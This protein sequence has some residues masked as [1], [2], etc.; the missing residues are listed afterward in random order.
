MKDRRFERVQIEFIKEIIDDTGTRSQLGRLIGQSRVIEIRNELKLY[1]I[2]KIYEGV[3]DDLN[4]PNIKTSD[5]EETKR[6]LSDRMK[7]HRDDPMTYEYILE[8]VLF[9]CLREVGCRRVKDSYGQNIAPK[10]E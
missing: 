9:N 6:Q 2:I 8:D 5:T 3:L 1:K 10:K 7:Q 4:S